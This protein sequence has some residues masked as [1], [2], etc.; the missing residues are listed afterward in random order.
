MNG[1]DCLEGQENW[2]GSESLGVGE[3]G[4]PGKPRDSPEGGERWA[5]IERCSRGGGSIWLEIVAETTARVWAFPLALDAA[6]PSDVGSCS[7]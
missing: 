4:K 6:G 7:V 2:E 3:P 1:L 5:A